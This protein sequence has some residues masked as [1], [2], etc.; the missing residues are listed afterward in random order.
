VLTSGVSVVTGH[1]FL[2]IGSS[3]GSLGF[4]GYI[5]KV[6]VWARLLSV[7]EMQA[8]THL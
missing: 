4:G 3:F 8:L 7:P 1:T 5:D 2:E 6:G